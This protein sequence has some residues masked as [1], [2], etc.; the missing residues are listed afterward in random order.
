ME[1][2]LTVREARELLKVDRVT[3]YR[4]LKDGR[5]DGIKVGHQWRFAPAEIE[6]L[7]ADGYRAEEEAPVAGPSRTLPLH[8]VQVLQNAF[9]AIAGVGAV[10]VSTQGQPLSEWSNPCAFCALVQTSEAGRRGCMSTWT[11]LAAQ[12]QVMPAYI[13]C[14]AGLQCLGARVAVNGADVATLVAGQFYAEPPD[15]KH[16]SKRLRALADK[17]QLDAGALVKASGTVAVLDFGRRRE[18][19][20]WTSSMARAIEDITAEAAALQG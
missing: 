10:T 7:L 9:A 13:T 5:L 15:R 4:M 19:G 2:L 14:H 18:L 6:A 3:I 11:R 20:H 16:E 17:L 12:C 1:R 8:C